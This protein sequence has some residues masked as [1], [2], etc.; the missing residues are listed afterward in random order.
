M[1]IASIAIVM[2]LAAPAAAQTVIRYEPK[3]EDLKYVFGAAKPVATVKPGNIIDTKTFDC[4]GNVIQKPG[5]A[6]SKVQGDNP[7]TG[8]FFVEGAKPG[9]TLAVNILEGRPVRGYT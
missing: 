1:K 6:L 7:P 9:D 3:A 4:F 8:P 5:D 2:G